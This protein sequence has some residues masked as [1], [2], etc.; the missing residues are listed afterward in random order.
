M[1]S[2]SFRVRQI[3][4]FFLHLTSSSISYRGTGMVNSD[5]VAVPE[6]LCTTEYSWMRNSLMQEPCLVAAYL[7]GQCGSGC[8][9]KNEE[10]Y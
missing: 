6:N 1:I 3:F 7:Q 10:S 4:L 5:W 9:Y 2:N 8:E